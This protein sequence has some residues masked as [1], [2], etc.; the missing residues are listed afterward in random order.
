MLGSHTSHGPDDILH[1]TK[2]VRSHAF[3]IQDEMGGTTS[4]TV[5]AHDFRKTLRCRKFE[6]A[7]NEIPQRSTVFVD[8]TGDEALVSRVKERE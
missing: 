7:A 2:H 8:I 5:Q 3:I 4:L 1:R 6:T